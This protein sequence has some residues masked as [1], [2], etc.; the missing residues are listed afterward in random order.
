MIKEKKPY[1][2][3]IILCS[4]MMSS[5]LFRAYYYTINEIQSI[6]IVDFLFF[7]AAILSTIYCFNLNKKLVIVSLLVHLTANIFDMFLIYNRQSL[8]YHTSF[9]SIL[10]DSV[11]FEILPLVLLL[12]G[13]F[14]N[15]KKYIFSSMIL[16]A[17]IYLC[18]LL[19]ALNSFREHCY[20]LDI[21]I[22]AFNI[23][24]PLYMLII[25]YNT[26]SSKF[27]DSNL[28]GTLESIP[29][30]KN[31]ICTEL[32]LEQLKEMLDCGEITV[33]EYN[34]KKNEIINQL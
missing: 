14:V 9:M 21:S 32:S 8:Y 34:Q 24:F 22:I 7:A 28:K 20:M 4:L 2:L 16:S 23:I 1:V 13:S 3:G 25:W 5:Y 29:T 17:L 11:I 26:I 31:L 12:V 33:A 18:T 19:S 15:R 27:I 10:L 6:D 30:Q